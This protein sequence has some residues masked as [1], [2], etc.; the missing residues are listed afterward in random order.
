MDIDTKKSYIDLNEEDS[1]RPKMDSPIK[2]QYKQNENNEIPKK[3]K[4]TFYC[5]LTLFILGVLLVIVGLIHTITSNNFS[6]GIPFWS[7]GGIVLI[8]GTYYTLAF[9]KIRKEKNEDVKKE[10]LDEIPEI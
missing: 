2:Q 7:I 3:L 5:S 8:P 1:E 9:H 4:K 6:K 10:M